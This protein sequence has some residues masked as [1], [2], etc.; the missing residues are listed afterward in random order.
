M[1]VG[2]ETKWNF[3]SKNFYSS[4]T[5][6]KNCVLIDELSYSGINLPNYLS[7][8]AIE[9]YKLFTLNMSVL[10]RTFFSSFRL[11]KIFKMKKKAN[12]T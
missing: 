11:L 6:T 7:D 9:N 4:V 12:S 1:I 8:Q 5:Y 3:R 2:Q 10:P